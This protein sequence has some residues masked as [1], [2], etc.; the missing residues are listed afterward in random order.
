VLVLFDFPSIPNLQFLG[1]L[2][3]VVILGLFAIWCYFRYG[4]K[5]GNGKRDLTAGELPREHWQ[6]EFDTIKTAIAEVRSVAGELKR[7]DEETER[8]IRDFISRRDP[9]WDALNH[10]LER[11]NAK[12]HDLVDEVNEVDAGVKLVRAELRKDS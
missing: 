2:A 9:Q 12:L 11:V 8:L 6:G 1:A 5:R 10:G 4:T 7:L 3:G